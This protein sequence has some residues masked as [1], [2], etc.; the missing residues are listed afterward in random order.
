MKKIEKNNNRG[1]T[2]VEVMVA[3][4]IVSVA[5][6]ALLMRM[7]SMA[8]ASVHNRTVTMAHWVVENQL[9]EV[10]IT[11]DLE[12]REPRGR[13]GGDVDMAGSKWDWNV[14]TINNDTAEVQGF[15][16]TVRAGPQGAE[17]MADLV[18]YLF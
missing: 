1:F 18:V 5:I 2:L 8:N 15:K 6:P 3:L 13:Q 11:R 7:E 16:M 9:Q 10:L 14:E 12:K 4:I 17:P